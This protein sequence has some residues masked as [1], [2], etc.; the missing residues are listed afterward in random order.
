MKKNMFK[1]NLQYFAA[2][3]GTGEGGG[4]GE[5]EG[6][7]QE[8][9]TGKESYTKDEV[10]Q[11]IQSESD[12]RVQQALKTQ[13][14]KYEKEL[15]KQKNLKNLTGLDKDARDAAEKDMLISEL[16][17][18]LSE[19]TLSNTKAEISKVLNNRGLDANLVDFVVT[20]DDTEECLEKIE[21]LDKIFKAMLK[22]EVD[23]RLKAGANTP[24]SSTTGL[25]GN[26]TR[27]QFAKMSLTE[28]AEVARNNRQL[29]DELTKR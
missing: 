25:D 2:D 13:Q 5:G 14:K 1:L 15:G 20:T 21:T 12:K 29:Y 27:E 17:E 23:T 7:L 11:L 28:Q 16:Q 9:G 8:D 3:T 4:A 26:I 22:K 24:K 6:L 19:L 18:R 10:L